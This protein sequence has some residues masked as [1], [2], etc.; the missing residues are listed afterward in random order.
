LTLFTLALVVLLSLVSAA[1]VAARFS[2]RKAIWG[3]PAVNG[4]SQFPLYRNLGVGIY[5]TSLSWAAI[6]P[7]RL[8]RPR[9][10][11]DAAY[12]WPAGLGS[13]I[14][15]ARRHGMR[16]LIALADAP[17]WANGGRTP[18]WAPRRPADY[19]DFAVAVARRYPSVHLWLVWGEPSRAGRFLPLTPS[20]PLS[21]RLTTRQAAAPRLYARILDAAYGA[22]KSVS[23]HNQVIGGNTYTGGNIRTGQWIRYLRLPNGRPP[24][25]D[26]YGHNPF[27]FRPPI[28]ANPPQPNALVDFSDLGRLAQ[29]ID[30]NLLRSRG[31]HIGLFLSEWTIPTA[32]DNEFAFYADVNTQAAWIR[33]GFRIVR[34]WPRI[35]A[36]G[37]IHI[38]DEGPGGSNGGLLDIHGQKKPGYYAFRAG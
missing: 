11:T 34:S 31:R 16:V 32:P 6:A 26:L 23:R 19:A 1:P 36:L 22:L 20:N 28:L 27:S 14:A 33:S 2:P 12:R 15:E 8:G 5:E 21:P 18:A 4:V 24:R 10:P 38:Y 25:M 30:R 7:T 3:P 35:Y 17:P 9:D 29:A 37:W 13:T